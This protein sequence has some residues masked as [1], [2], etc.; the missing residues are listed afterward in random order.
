MATSSGGGDVGEGLDYG[1][2]CSSG[3]HRPQWDRVG[4]LCPTPPPNPDGLRDLDSDSSAGEEGVLPSSSP[5]AEEANKGAVEEA[6]KAAAPAHSLGEAVSPF[7]PS[8]PRP[9]SHVHYISSFLLKMLQKYSQFDI[10]EEEDAA[11]Q[12]TSNE[13]SDSIFYEGFVD[14]VILLAAEE[15]EPESDIKRM[16]AQYISSTHCEGDRDLEDLYDIE[17]EE[18]GDDYQEIAVL[19]PVEKKE[20]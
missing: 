20:E 14:H 1:R 6:E 9:E 12:D 2:A 5:Y 8:P 11:N 3:G 19:D 13:D 15:E 7:A 17:L 10:D 16:R 18:D 4:D